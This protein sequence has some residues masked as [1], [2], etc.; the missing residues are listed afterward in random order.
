MK[1]PFRKSGDGIRDLQKALKQVQA[2]RDALHRKV[3]S[4]EAA[5][6][7]N[8]HLAEVGRRVEDMPFRSSLFHGIVADQWSYQDMDGWCNG[9]SPLAALP[10]IRTKQK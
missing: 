5:V 3:V 2:E 8:A 4:L 6:Q 10:A 1:W 7:Q 9:A